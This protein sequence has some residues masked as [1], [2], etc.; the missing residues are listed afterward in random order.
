MHRIGKDD[1]LQFNKLCPIEKGWSGDKKYKAV[2]ADGTAYL[3]RVAPLEKR[4]KCA[5]MFTL[6]QQYTALGI[7]MCEPIE[8]TLREDGVYTV[9]RFVKGRD[10]EEVLPTLSQAEQYALGLDAGHILRTMHRIPAPTDAPDWSTR[11]GAKID[12]KIKMYRD[13]PIK[14]DGAEEIIRYLNSRRELLPGRP[15]AFQHGDYHVGNMMIENGQLVIIDF[16]R[17]DYGDPWEEFNRIVWCAQ[18]SPHFAAGQVDGYFDGDVPQDFWSLLA[19]YI[20][21]N[22]LSSIPWAIPFGE[23][24]INTMREQAREV[25]AWYDGMQRP[26]PRWYETA[27]STL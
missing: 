21:S 1:M 10:A 19:L 23:D 6:Q 2:T 14:F 12:R 22:T 7:P 11:F 20:G 3:L 26:L 18:A 16:D 15:Q 5:A 4:E 13:C 9:Q 17:L 24:E 27:K 25:L 8:Q